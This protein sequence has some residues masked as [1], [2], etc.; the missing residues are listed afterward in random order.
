MSIKAQHEISLWY[1]SVASFTCSCQYPSCD[2][3]PQF[4]KMLPLGGG[5]G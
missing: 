5:A 3:V 4:C 1:G 2:L